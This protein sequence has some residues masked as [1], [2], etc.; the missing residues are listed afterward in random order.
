[1]FM[2]HPRIDSARRRI[3]AAFLLGVVVLS[4]PGC[5]NPQGETGLLTQGDWG[6]E[7]IRLS[8]GD[9]SAEVE[10]DCAHGTINV[11]ILLSAGEFSA[12]GSFTREHGGP[13]REGE[14]VL[15]QPARYSGTVLGDYMKLTVTLTD[16]QRA[17]G[18]FELRRGADA[19]VFK[20]L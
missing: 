15:P 20:C 6:G 10:Y 9:S 7:H 14:L 16:E 5:A 13:V 3:H 12:V 8:V 18:T 4:R 1:M 11:P 17:V 19:R 2:V